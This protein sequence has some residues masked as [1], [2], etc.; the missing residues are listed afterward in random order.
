MMQGV[1]T[2]EKLVALCE[3]TLIT[4]RV[5]RYCLQRFLEKTDLRPHFEND[6]AIE[7]FWRMPLA[8]RT[9]LWG[10]ALD[11][12]WVRRQFDKSLAFAVIE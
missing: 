6:A 9:L 11:M 3:I 2:K 10:H 8:E 4:E 5:A 7:A 12:A 1:T